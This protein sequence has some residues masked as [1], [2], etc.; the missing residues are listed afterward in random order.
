WTSILLDQ[1][2]YRVKRQPHR[3]VPGGFHLV[4]TEEVEPRV[5]ER[6][7]VQGEGGRRVDESI[8]RVESTLHAAGRLHGETAHG[9]RRVITENRLE[10][11]LQMRPVGLEGLRPGPTENHLLERPSDASQF[12]RS[13]RM[14]KP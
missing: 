3:V 4:E 12:V 5:E 7:E 2:D 1:P 9:A 10:L 6:L 11:V 14:T 8:C 13:P